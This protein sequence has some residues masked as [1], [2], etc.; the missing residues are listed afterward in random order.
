MPDSTADRSPWIVVEAPARLHVGFIDL[1]GGLGRCFGSIGL[2]LDGLATRLRLRPAAQASAR[3]PQAERAADCLHRL[4]A[5]LDIGGAEVVV[6]EAIPAHAGLGS[7]TQMALAAGCALSEA[8]GL[9]LSP[10]E[11]AHLLDRGA[12]SGIGVAA[13]EQGG[14]VVDGGRGRSDA[15]PPLVSR[16]PFPAHWRILLILDH[17]VRGLHGAAEVAA[18]RD[19][20]PFPPEQAARMAR[21]TLMQILP[22]LAEAD[23][24]PFGR[25]VGELQRT[26]GDHFAPAQGGRYASPRVARALAF[27]E[28]Q[29]ICCV[30]QS[31][32]GP[33]GFAIVDSAQRALALERALR[34]H[35]GGECPLELRIVQGSNRG[36]RMRR[37]AAGARIASSRG[38]SRAAQ[39]AVA[40]DSAPNPN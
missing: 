9:G 20:P 36:A 22:A 24:E 3:G 6:E 7:G 33:T 30:G 25:G 29:G 21:L 15:P 34:E 13:F 37:E 23:L 10:R 1:D 4:A 27:L 11:I 40:V 35:L 32:W 31:S 17:G 28:A 18:F 5:A 19:L 14:F 26:V 12:R 8:L 38:W 39:Q 16:L 2:A